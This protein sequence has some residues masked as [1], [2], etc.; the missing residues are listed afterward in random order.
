MWHLAFLWAWFSA[1]AAPSAAVSAG[2]V[3]SLCPR[4]P[5]AAAGYIEGE[6]HAPAGYHWHPAT[7]CY[8]RC[9]RARCRR[10][11]R[12]WAYLP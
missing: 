11:A 2:L 12:R 9:H 5:L 6:S 7:R 1:Y 8:R 4:R 3:M 10:C